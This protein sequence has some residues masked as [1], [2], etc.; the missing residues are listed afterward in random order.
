MSKNI[1][2]DTFFVN[3]ERL[4]ALM[5]RESDIRFAGGPLGVLWAYLPP[6]FWIG[7]VALVFYV[8][9]SPL[10][11]MTEPALFVATGI[12]PYAIFRQGITSMMRSIKVNRLLPL[13]PEVTKAQCLLATAIL[14]WLTSIMLAIFIFGG[15]SLFFSVPFPGNLFTVCVALTV[16]WALGVSVGALFA[17]IGQ[18]SDTFSR[19]VPIILRPLFWIS[20]I[21]YTV[22][23][24]PSSIQTMLSYNPLVHIIESLREGYFLG[25]TSPVSN[26][27]IPVSTILFSIIATIYVEAWIE[28][29]KANRHL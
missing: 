4:I 29:K 14:E 16:A 7:L 6:L 11:I 20:A 28:E 15:V 27:I 18:V 22:S 9:K 10:P 5:K 26:L 2:Q 13:L 1:V 21:F 23:Q 3:H 12:L 25:Y 24:V 19:S 17:S 8:L